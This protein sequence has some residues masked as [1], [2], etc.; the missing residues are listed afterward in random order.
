MKIENI[1]KDFQK[2]CC[3]SYKRNYTK[4]LLNIKT[5]KPEAI[6]D[7][8]ER[9]EN[10]REVVFSGG[11]TMDDS[12]KDKLIEGILHKCPKLTKLSMAYTQFTRDQIERLS[13][14]F[15]N[16]TYLKL[17][18]C[19]LDEQ[20]MQNIFTD[21]CK[22][23]KTLIISGNTMLTGSCLSNLK[24]VE[25]LDASYCFDLIHTEFLKFL[26]NCIFLKSLDI[27][28]CIKLSNGSIIE[29]IHVYQPKIETLIFLYVGQNKESLVFSRFQH[30][31]I[32]DVYGNNYLL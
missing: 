29:D 15:K 2:F 18:R 13:G 28:A 10:V 11:F 23:L 16:L 6:S 19:N 21:D 8:F 1:S 4:L 3:L 24:Y 12:I 30:L 7:I 31:K 27:S 5:L 14:C 20:N 25:T 9:V 32:L 17:E 22:S 26:K